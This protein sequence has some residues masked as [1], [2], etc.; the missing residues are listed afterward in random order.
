MTLIDLNFSGS[1]GAMIF[2]E[3]IP[4]QFLLRENEPFPVPSMSHEPPAWEPVS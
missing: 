2:V 4:G 1:Y 3:H